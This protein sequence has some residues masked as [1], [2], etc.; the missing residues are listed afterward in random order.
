MITITLMHLLNIKITKHY[1]EY[2]MDYV[3]IFDGMN[4]STEEPSCHVFVVIYIKLAILSAKLVTYHWI[5]TLSMSINV[6]YRKISV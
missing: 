3:H 1:N 4:L 5:K 6:L 2:S